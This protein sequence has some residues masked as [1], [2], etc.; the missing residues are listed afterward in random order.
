M[1]TPP[2][3]DL[4]PARAELPRVLMLGWEFPPVI[5]GGLGVACHDLCIAMSKYANVTMIIPKSNPDFVVKNLNLIGL[6][7]IDAKTLRN[8]GHADSYKKVKQVH[9]INTH[10][11]PYYNNNL[12][13]HHD[14][15]NL[16]SQYLKTI[17]IGNE[18]AEI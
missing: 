11:N 7:T 9:F 12:E 17:K 10:L 18:T 6:N 4:I 13:P 1:T 15:Q 2:L 8:I 5:N 3:S 16:S 14:L